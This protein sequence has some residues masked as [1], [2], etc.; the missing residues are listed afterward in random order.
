[1]QRKLKAGECIDVSAC[2]R[3]GKYYVLDAFVDDVDYCDARAQ[4]WIWSIGRRYSDG[5]ILASTA[6]DLYLHD[7]FECLFLR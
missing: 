1:M 5:V 3:D 4:A 7:E 6:D 2:A